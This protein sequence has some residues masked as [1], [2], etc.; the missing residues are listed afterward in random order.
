MIDLVE[1][2][3]IASAFGY[4]E[5]RPV[6][7]H[8]IKEHPNSPWRVWAEYQMIRT[9]RLGI[10]LEYSEE[11]LRDLKG[12]LKKY[13]DCHLTPHCLYK[14]GQ[15]Y[16]ERSLADINSTEDREEAIRYFNRILDDYPDL[17]VYCALARNGLKR[18]PGVSVVYP[19]AYSEKTDDNIRSFYYGYHWSDGVK[20][21]KKVVS[22]YKKFKEKQWNK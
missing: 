1:L 7:E 8:I 14:I 20:K 11:Y 15:T 3:G 10:K 9:Y 22:D 5:K 21:T 12:F 18:I 4:S 6:L 13:P 16:C 2:A 19:E 17:E